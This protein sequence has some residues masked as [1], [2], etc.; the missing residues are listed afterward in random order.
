M[1]VLELLTSHRSNYGHMVHLRLCSTH[2]Y[3]IYTAPCGFINEPSPW[4]PPFPCYTELH[5]TNVQCFQG[6]YCHLHKGACVCQFHAWYP[7]F[8]PYFYRSYTLGFAS[9]NIY[10]SESR[11]NIVWLGQLVLTGTSEEFPGLLSTFWPFIIEQEVCECM[12][13]PVPWVRWVSV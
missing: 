5:L 1:C 6:F 3:S 7:L 11:G 8:S 12:C 4:I 10:L 13:V 9:S 2:T